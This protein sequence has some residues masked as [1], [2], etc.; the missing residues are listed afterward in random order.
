MKRLNVQ[1]MLD[2]LRAQGLTDREIARRVGVQPSAICSWSMGDKRPHLDNGWPLL[3]LHLALCRERSP[4]RMVV[5]IH[6]GATKYGGN[7]G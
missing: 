7:D 4:V 5:E 3:C 6:T 2:D 1:L